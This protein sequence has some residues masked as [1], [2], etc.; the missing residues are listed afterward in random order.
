[1]SPM[2]A[3]AIF[4]VV[5]TA[6]LA[7]AASWAVTNRRPVKPHAPVVGRRATVYRHS[8]TQLQDDRGITARANPTAV[9]HR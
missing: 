5:T 6:M 3:I 9:H 4:L 8:P 1:M 2:V 7:M